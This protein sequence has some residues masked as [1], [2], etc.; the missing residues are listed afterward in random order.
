M[1]SILVSFHSTILVL[2]FVFA[3]FLITVV[4]L[5]SG[6]GSDVGTAFGVGNSQTVFGAQG[7][8]TFL[9]KLTTGAA[10]L[11]LATSLFLATTSKLASTGGST[12]SMLQNELGKDAQTTT[13]GVGA[14]TQKTD[15]VPTDNQPQ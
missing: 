10:I 8:S 5:Q 3:L 14:D 11:F 4:L 9:T 6:K 12:E 15:S 1:A 7:A 13:N 2:H